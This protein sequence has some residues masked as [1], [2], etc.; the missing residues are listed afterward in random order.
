MPVTR[1]HIEL[2]YQRLRRHHDAAV[3]KP[4][5]VSVLDV[6]HCLRIWVEMKREV[7]VSLAQVPSRVRFAHSRKSGPLRDMLKGTAFTYLPL[8]TGWS[9][10]G[11]QV[12]GM[13]VVNRVLTPEEI[14]RLYEMGPP[15]PDA[16]TSTFS[17]WLGTEI[18]EVRDPVGQRLGLSRETLI[19]RVANILGAS[20]PIGAEDSDRENH[21][22]PYVRELHSL[23]LAGIP[24]TFYQMMEIAD[25]LIEAF[26]PLFG[27]SQA[28]GPHQGREG[29]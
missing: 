25:D 24:A 2:Q 3:G 4:D 17:E 14:K 26:E 9:S 15:R 20:H 8:A 13:M 27:R 19:K 28:G 7:D 12:K 21:F 6:T 23:S 10:P 18:Y 22:D 29:A 11:V 1:D 5:S 16:V